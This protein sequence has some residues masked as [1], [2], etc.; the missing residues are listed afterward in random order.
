MD[1]THTLTYRPKYKIGDTIIIPSYQNSDYNNALKV[2]EELLNVDKSH[3]LADN[4]QY[5][6]G[7]IFTIIS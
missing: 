3:D 2:F 1:P 7:E 4:S 5:W 6:L